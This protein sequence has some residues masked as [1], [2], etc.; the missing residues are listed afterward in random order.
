MTEWTGKQRAE[1]VAL[2]HYVALA[3]ATMALVRERRE[4]IGAFAVAVAQG[5]RGS[6]TGDGTAA[7]ATTHE[8]VAID[9]SS[10]SLGSASVESFR[11]GRPRWAAS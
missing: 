5:G 7:H 9:F 4:S 6:S 10:L 3:R 8:A 2:P 1:A 11:F